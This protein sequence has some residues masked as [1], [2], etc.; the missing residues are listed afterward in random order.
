MLGCSVARR[1]PSAAAAPRRLG[2]SDDYK[3]AHYE[4]GLERGRT[5][6]AFVS[7]H[8]HMDG[9]NGSIH[10]GGTD[11]TC[12]AGSTAVVNAG[13]TEDGTGGMAG[14]GRMAQQISGRVIHYYYA[15][16]C[17]GGSGSAH[18]RR[19]ARAR[20]VTRT[21]NSETWIGKMERAVHG[22][23]Y[24]YEGLPWAGVERLAHR[25][26]LMGIRAPQTPWV[27]GCA[28]RAPRRATLHHSSTPLHQAQQ[29]RWYCM[30]W[31]SR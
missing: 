9:G 17:A 25:R 7:R 23:A 21:V 6:Q 5:R 10:G 27:S 29:R 30:L 2:C 20:R 19:H 4:T 24:G 3:R 12:L 22:A 16:G 8:A 1:A 15:C 18:R 14:T 11:N 28:G 31:E 13:E 26:S